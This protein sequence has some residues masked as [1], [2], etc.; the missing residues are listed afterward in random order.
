MK[1]K[2]GEE[3]T[4]FKS[5]RVEGEDRVRIEFERPP[6]DLEL[7]P[8]NA[9][10]L[11]WESFVAVLNRGGSIC[12]RRILLRRPSPAHSVRVAV[13]RTVRDGAVGGSGLNSRASNAGA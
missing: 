10:G 3:G 1:L 4:I 6:L 11:D 2:G 8:K 7:D 12:S 9:P 13:V 5:L